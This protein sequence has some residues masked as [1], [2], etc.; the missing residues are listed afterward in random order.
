MSRGSYR[1]MTCSPTYAA[2]VMSKG[3]V[4]LPDVVWPFRF[5]AIEQIKG[6]AIGFGAFVCQREQPWVQVFHDPIHRGV[7]GDRPS[8][9]A[10]HR[11]HL[12]VDKCH[13]GWRRAQ[14]K[15]FNDL[16]EFGP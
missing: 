1:M 10:R 12:A 7:G 16:L 11:T 3:V 13:G 8:V 5:A 14:G 2:S 4:S 6:G 9:L 15:P